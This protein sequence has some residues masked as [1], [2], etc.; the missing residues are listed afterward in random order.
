MIF[1]ATIGRI[2]FTFDETKFEIRADS[3]LGAESPLL[4]LPDAVEEL[5]G[6]DEWFEVF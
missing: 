3:H 5:L 2:T 6:V 1:V 4:L